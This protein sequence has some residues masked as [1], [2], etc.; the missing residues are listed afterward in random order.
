MHVQKMSWRT[1]F[2]ETFLLIIAKREHL[3]YF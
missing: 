3:L 1:M 2:A